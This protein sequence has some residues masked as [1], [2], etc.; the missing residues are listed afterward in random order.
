MTDLLMSIILWLAGGYVGARVAAF[1][2]RGNRLKFWGQILAGMLGGVILGWVL[3]VFP[4]LEPVTRFLHNGHVE[5]AIA[6][7]LGGLG[8]GTLGQIFAPAGAREGAGK[9]KTRGGDNSSSGS[10][11]SS[12]AAFPA[13][14]GQRS[15]DRTDDASSGDSQPDAGGGGDGGGGD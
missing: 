7:L 8:L 13:A 3:D 5:D 9:T 11:A 14:A 12:V 2:N 10:D 15:H 4:L 1:F 6:G